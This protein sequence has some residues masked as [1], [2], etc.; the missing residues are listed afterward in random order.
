VKL[1]I[2]GTYYW[3]VEYTGNIENNAFSETAC[4]D[5]A[6][7]VVVTK[8]PSQVVTTPSIKLTEDINIKL[9]ASANAGIQAGDT[10]DVSLFKEDAA[11]TGDGCLSKGHAGG[12]AT[13][14]GSTN[15]VTLTTGAGGNYD[16]A[17]GVVNITL[18]YPEDF[19]PGAPA[20]GNGDYHWF[21]V[22]NGNSQVTGSNDDCNEFF[23]ISG[24]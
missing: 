2:P 9:S 21:V 13:Q 1:T 6:E 17:T 5:S 12:N 16:P 18:K 4:G 3:T 14:Q 22:Y 11:G 24:L 10:V 8:A 7:K 19:Q 23:S 15:T 20:I